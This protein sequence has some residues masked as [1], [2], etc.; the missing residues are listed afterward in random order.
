MITHNDWSKQKKY[1]FDW[2]E[3]KAFD[4][5]TEELKVEDLN[6]SQ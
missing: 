6:L 5:I 4:S 3:K 1:G 2:Q